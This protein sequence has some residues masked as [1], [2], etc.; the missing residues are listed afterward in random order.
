MRSELIPHQRGSVVVI[1]TDPVTHDYS[2]VVDLVL[3]GRPERRKERVGV[4]IGLD[5]WE[6]RGT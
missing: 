3:N 5:G 2:L 1:S 4:G 6:E